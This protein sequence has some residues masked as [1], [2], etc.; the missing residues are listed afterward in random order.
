MTIAVCSTT[1][2]T[3]KDTTALSVFHGGGVGGGTTHPFLITVKTG[4]LPRVR[5]V[6]EA[7]VV[8]YDIP[9]DFGYSCLDSIAV[10]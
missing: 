5:E 6:S 7:D 1:V 9:R 4:F 10:F 2:S 8:D 3:G